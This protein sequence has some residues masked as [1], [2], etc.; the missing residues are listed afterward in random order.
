MTR[1]IF[2]SAHLDVIFSEFP[3]LGRLHVHIAV[4]IKE[5]ARRLAR[6]FLTNY[7]IRLHREA[8]SIW[9]R[10]AGV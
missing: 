9:A 5:E 3:E 8:M 6:L 4:G 1:S 7:S 2:F 10:E